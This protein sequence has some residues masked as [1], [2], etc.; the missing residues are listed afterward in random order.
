MHGISSDVAQIQEVMGEVVILAL[1]I[2]TYYFKIIQVHKPNMQKDQLKKDY[3]WIVLESFHVYRYLQ[4][5][6]NKDIKK[7]R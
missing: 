5:C 1:T 3:V 4:V 6:S 2:S 7:L